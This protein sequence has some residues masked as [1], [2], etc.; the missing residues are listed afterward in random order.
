MK[1]KNTEILTLKDK[2][3][4]GLRGKNLNYKYRLD[5]TFFHDNN[6]KSFSIGIRVDSLSRDTNGH[7]YFVVRTLNSILIFLQNNENK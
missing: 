1:N 5:Q 7:K 4:K 3:L 6:I 2:Q